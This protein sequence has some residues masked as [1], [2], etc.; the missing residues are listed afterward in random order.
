MINDRIV[1]DT[2]IDVNKLVGLSEG[3]GVPGLGHTKHQIL[4]APAGA[5]FV[6]CNQQEKYALHLA[7]SV[8]RS[9]LKVVP[10]SWLTSNEA[11]RSAHRDS[12]VV[13]HAY[14]RHNKNTVI[15]R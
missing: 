13:D 1:P 8:G 11:H 10:A 3:E 15:L 12:I 5:W 9:D 14:E 6:W 4:T 2:W 7:H